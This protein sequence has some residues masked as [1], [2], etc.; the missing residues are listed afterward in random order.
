MNEGHLAV[1]FF[2]AVFWRST[3]ASQS[4]LLCHLPFLHLVQRLAVDAQ[5]CRRARFQ[6]LDADLDTALAAE[7]IVAA[8]DAAQRLVDFLD[9][10]AFTVAVTEFD[11]NVRF[12]AG[13]VVGVGKHRRF[14]LHGV[15]SA[16]DVFAQLLFERFE[17]LAEMRELLRAHVVFAR[18]WFIRCEVFMEQFFCHFLVR[19][20]D[21]KSD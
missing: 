5:G 14:V 13:P 8:F 4:G 12:L 10:F 15:H 6:A 16:I 21:E 1:P 9:Q 18:F 19:P 2:F 11:G 7:A 17:N 20:S 3:A